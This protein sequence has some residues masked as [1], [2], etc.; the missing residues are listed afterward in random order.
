M[1]RRLK[2]KLATLATF[3]V[4]ILLFCVRVTG[5][6]LHMVAGLIFIAVLAIHTITRRRRILKCPI[7][8]RAVDI[9]SLIAML[10]V[11]VTGFMIPFFKG[12][13]AVV[14]LH[15]LT[16]VMLAVGIIVHICQHKPK[17]PKK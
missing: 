15:K 17:K 1:D 4:L 9:V 14:I 8:W 2:R 11:L 6:H 5:V 3:F 16:S 7:R 10:A 12:S 13:M